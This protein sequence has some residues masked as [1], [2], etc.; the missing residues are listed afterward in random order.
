VLY[1]KEFK[2]SEIIKP[3]GH[4]ADML[5][6]YKNQIV[7]QNAAKR[8]QVNTSDCGGPKL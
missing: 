4:N 8:P 1:R 3:I 7:T 2:N 6:K 5:K